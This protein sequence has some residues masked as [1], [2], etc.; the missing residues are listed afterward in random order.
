MIRFLYVTTIFIFSLGSAVAQEIWLRPEKYFYE[1]GDRA[2]IQI[3]NG[4]NFIGTP[5]PVDQDRIAVLQLWNRLGH[6]DIRSTYTPNE[7]ASFSVQ[8]PQQGYHLVLMKTDASY[9]LDG[10]AFREY[11]K[12]Y[13][14][15]EQVGDIGTAN[16]FKLSLTHR[17]QLSLRSGKQGGNGWTN[18]ASF[19]VE[20][21]PD[22]NPQV[23]R[24]GDRIE[25]KV[26][27]DGKP[28]FGVRVKIWNRWD[29]RTTIQNIYTQQDGMISTTISNPGDWMVTV[30]KLRKGA[31]PNSF[32]GEAFTL[33]FGYR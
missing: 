29:N 30:V 15:E 11:V 19:P 22:K 18:P 16:E 3:Q 5:L 23:L 17:I 8:I 33:L 26:L 7:K 10:E 2:E 13:G 14:L 25:F 12:Q 21:L 1:P 24:R 31:D 32:T 20:V 28:A 6:S 9:T 27:E 4:E